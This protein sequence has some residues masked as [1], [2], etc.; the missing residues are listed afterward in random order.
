[1]R[2]Q[3]KQI[4]SIALLLFLSL[5]I[6]ASHA[7]YIH[8]ARSD[9]TLLQESQNDVLV[10]AALPSFRHYHH[11]SELNNIDV[12]E[13]LLPLNAK[14]VKIEVI[15]AEGSI[16]IDALTAKNKGLKI[17]KPSR[18]RKAADLQ[19]QLKSKAFPV[20]EA[21][22]NLDE[23][24]NNQ[25]II[26]AKDFKTLKF[27]IKAVIPAIYTLKATVDENKSAEI[28][29]DVKQDF[30]IDTV[31]PSILDTGVERI[32]TIT[33]RGLDIFTQIFIGEGVQILKQVPLDHESTILEVKVIADENAVKGFR[34]VIASNLISER[35]S[36]LVNG[37][38][39]GPQI[40]M[41][42]LPGVPGIQGPQGLVGADGMSFCEHFSDSLM[43]FAN[44]LPAGNMPT[45]FFDP[46]GCNLS[47]GIPVGFNGINGSDG[48]SINGQDGMSVCTNMSSSLA[49][50]TNTLPA[51]SMSTSAFD[52]D[53][54]TL[55]LGIP[56][57]AS[58][59][60]GATGTTGASGLNC[61]DLNENNS[62]DLLT[63]DQ[64]NDGAC[65]AIDCQG[66]ANIPSIET[67]IEHWN[68]YSNETNYTT[69]SGATS[70]MV[71]IPYFIH[72][73]IIYGGFWVDKYES[74]KADATATT[75]GTST[76][77]VSKRGVVPWTNIS[78]ASAKV[79]SNSADRQISG[80][81]SCKLIG[82][83][84]WYALYLLG[85]YAKQNGIFGSTATNGWNERGNTRSGRD[86]RNDP[87]KIC[88][89]D[90]TENSGGTGRCLTGTGYKSWGHILDQTAS[91]N[92]D[93][94]IF[95]D[96]SDNVNNSIN[97]FDGDLQVYDLVGN[98]REWIDFTVTRASNATKVDSG[99][100]AVGLTLP[101]ITNNRFFSFADIA[102]NSATS[103]SA[104]D[105]EFRGLGLPRT[106]GTANQTDVNGAAN[107]G[108]I[109]TSTTN[110]QYGT[111]RGGSW[112]TSTESRSPLYLNISTTP[113]TTETQRGFRV[114]CDFQE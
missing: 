11:D 39:V 5:C 94:S 24:G 55:V 92:V 30:R 67:V 65:S 102:G 26:K 75:E 35:S 47:F 63:E 88:T 112:T 84:E 83:R 51:G 49:I 31:T 64:N 96:T 3:N 91:K 48:V 108:K 23:I 95:G 79:Y 107:D 18:V 114:I 14:T 37:L 85:R 103:T 87:T 1:M 21:I 106:G 70:R 45:V 99:Y 29:I 46:I 71:K 9:S 113:D 73:G 8:S 76:T 19:K 57:G 98:V 54:C 60:T 72:D 97:E 38:Y 74:S 53:A 50:S 40:G 82:M 93:G 105:I 20:G 110:Q 10:N 101:Y 77:P 15:S 111:V 13:L 12:L 16:G 109:L 22:F 4:I 104:S 89:D 41:D 33:G 44:N 59:A 7:V 100:Q 68:V 80:L 32:L 43:V 34:D 66:A 62:C 86:G 58:G 27:K 61:W 36:T 78:F 25:N 52:A 42:G 69:N 6:K 90:P 56:E 17:L 2:K 81:G 28:Q